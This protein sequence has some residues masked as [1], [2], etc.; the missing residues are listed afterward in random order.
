MH[1]HE[2]SMNYIPIKEAIISFDIIKGSYIHMGLNFMAIYH[3]Y[4]NRV[5]DFTII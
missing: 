5:L 4:M 3:I 1:A 2:G